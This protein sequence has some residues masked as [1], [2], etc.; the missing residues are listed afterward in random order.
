[1]KILLIFAMTFCAVYANA[2]TASIEKPNILSSNQPPETVELFTTSMIDLRVTHDKM[3]NAVVCDVIEIHNPLSDTWSEFPIGL[4]TMICFCEN[5]KIAVES[6]KE[7]ET[8]MTA[9]FKLID[10]ANPTD[11]TIFELAIKDVGDGIDIHIREQ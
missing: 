10:R 11:Q 3:V 2:Q 9:R 5:P 7:T 8:V 1:M 4:L 6:V